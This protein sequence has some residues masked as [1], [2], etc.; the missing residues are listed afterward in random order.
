MR[1]LLPVTGISLLMAGCAVGPDYEPRYDEVPG[2][3]AF[4]NAEDEL[5]SQEAVAENWW[6]LYDSPSLNAAIQEALQANRDLQ[7]ASANLERAQAV[8]RQSSSQR[9]PSTEISVSETY[10]RDNFFLEE[11]LP[12]ENNVYTADLNINYQIDLFGRV[13]RAI[14]AA[15]ASAEAMAAA[16]RST[17]VTIAAET[18]RAWANACAAGYQ[19]RVAENSL[20]LQQRSLELTTQLRDAG[21]GTALDV[22]RAAS[23]AAQTRASVP[24]LRAGRDAALYRLAVLMGREPADFPAEAAECDTPLQLDQRIPVGDGA[25]L[26]ARRPDVRQAERELA[27]A[28]ARVGV[29]TAELY[30]SVSFGAA[31]GSSALSGA[32]LFSSETETWSYGPM[33]NWVFP[34]ISGTLA[35]Q[36][37]AEADMGAALAGF[38][39]AWLNAL[40]ETETVLSAYSNELESLDALQEARDHS[41]E[42]VRI[43]R[44]RYEA[45]RINFLDLLQSELTLTEAEMSLAETRSRIA[46]LQID[47]FLALGG[48]WSENP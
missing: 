26:L 12:V 38:E 11:P 48:G 27:A 25:G 13:R 3:E 17:Q 5:F 23:V 33:I 4:I 44:A 15:E 16:Y 35:R 10:S 22:A 24:G 1:K 46:A 30:P 7:I 21:R 28:T 31:I 32:G 36:A 14:E 40:R 45:G 37:Q 6:R 20:S 8:L 42:A 41:E 2:Q 34:N 19:V 29:A 47:L 18:A 9:L 39:G 43:A